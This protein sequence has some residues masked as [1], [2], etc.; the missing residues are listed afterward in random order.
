MENPVSAKKETKIRIAGV[1]VLILIIFTIQLMGYTWSRIQCLQIGYEIS[2]EAEKY[3]SQL[4]LQNNLK[5][6]I[7]RLKSPERI[8][9]RAQEVGMISPKPEQTIIIHDIRK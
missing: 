9:K 8:A 2:E 4:V 7:A 1:W 6:E 3:Q 5:I